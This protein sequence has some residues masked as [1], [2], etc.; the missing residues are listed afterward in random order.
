M[1][2]DGHAPDG[3]YEAVRQHF[4]EKELSNLTVAVAAIN[5]WNRLSIAAQLTPGTYQAA[6]VAL[7]FEDG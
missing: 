2:A 3:T 7:P 1:I 5:A 6:K 4:N